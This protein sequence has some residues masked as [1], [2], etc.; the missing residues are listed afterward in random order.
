[1]NRSIKIGIGAAV[2]LLAGLIAVVMVR[3]KPG[4]P[5]ELTAS[6][7]VP[8]ELTAE[9]VLRDDGRTRGSA[10]APVTLI[11]YSD[12]TCGYC[13]KFF[14]E[15]WPRLRSKYIDSGK[16]RFLY[17]DFPR[18]NGGPGLQLAL[19]SRCAGAQDRYWQM[20]DRLFARPGEYGPAALREHAKAIGLDVPAFTQ[21]MQ[22][23]RATMT[24]YRDRDEGN[25][26]GF[27]GTPGFILLQTKG[28]NR[29]A[30]IAMPGAFPFDVFEEQIEQLLRAA[31]EPKGSKRDG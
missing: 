21:C 25:S 10:D 3:S 14:H 1:M 13:Q 16:V 17:R 7:E 2:L 15:T 24:I 27:R 29:P 19:A 26:L 11:E 12:F 22:E 5:V 23:A 18:A 9:Y 30:P 31:A 8:I 6:G 28:P 4:P 20:H